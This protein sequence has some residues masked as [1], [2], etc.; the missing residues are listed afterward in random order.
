MNIKPTGNLKIIKTKITQ[1]NAAVYVDA[2][3]QDEKKQVFAIHTASFMFD[4][5]H[6]PELSSLTK[7]RKR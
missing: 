4:L 7:Q 5:R 6:I 1:N 3:L 2:Y